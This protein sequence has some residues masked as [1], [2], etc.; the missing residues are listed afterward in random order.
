M[1][2]NAEV[3]CKVNTFF[4][5][6]A[7]HIKKHSREVDLLR[8]YAR[9]KN[10][11]ILHFLRQGGALL[12]FDEKHNLV[13]AAGREVFAR[14]IAGDTTYTGEVTD[15]ALGNGVS[16]SF[17]SASTQLNSEVGRSPAS[18]SAFDGNIAYVDFFFA[19]GDIANGTYTEWGTFID[20]DGSTANDGVAFSLLATGGW[21]K[22]GSVYIAAKYTII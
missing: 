8:E 2:L 13:A 15:G 11:R 19:S 9:T 14:R 10:E 6:L 18:D 7:P 21:V 20:G 17:T 12:N 5:N 22:S 4:A 3:K 1:K 16:P